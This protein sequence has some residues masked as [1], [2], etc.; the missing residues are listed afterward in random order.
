MTKLFISDL[1]LHQTRPEVTGLFRDFID[2][3]LTI[4]TPNPELYILGDLFEFWIGDDFEDPLYS[5]ITNQLKNLVKSGIKTYLMHG[6]RDFLIGEN[7]LSMTGIE[8]LKEP[9]IFSY[10]EKNIM[11]SHGDQFCIDDIEYQAYRKIVRNQ[12]WQRS[13]LSFPIDKRLKIL[14][15]ARD[16][17]I[18]SQDMKS[19]EIMDV[20]VNE[21]AA[22][23]QK[24]NIDILIHGHTHRPRSHT[25]DIETK[26]SVR[27]V[28][29]DWSAS[30]AKIIK[31]V[32]AEPQLID[33]I[34]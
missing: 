34:N 20:N 13:F 4:T 32:N 12:E 1:H 3:L 16:A 33:L 9:T 27:L 23:I 7:F 17:S 25:I 19:N 21:V 5:E 29:G 24:N 14:N 15:E 18:Q 30:S 22:V 10:K 26:K 8:L 11:L 31:W 2:E 28:L 6:N